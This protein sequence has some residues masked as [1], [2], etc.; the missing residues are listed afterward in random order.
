MRRLVVTVPSGRAPDVLEAARANGAEGVVTLQGEADGSSVDVVLVETANRELEGLVDQLGAIDRMRLSMFPH[1]VLGLKPP[2]EEAPDQVVDVTLRSPLEIL[3]D[4]L[5]SIGSWRGFLAYA[6]VAGIV[7]WIGLIT[8][9]VYLLTA[10]MLIAPFAGPAMNTA[11]GTARG[12][13]ALL[14]RSVVRYA[15]ALAVGVATAWLLTILF[16]FEQPTEQMLAATSISRTAVLLPLVAGAAGAINLGQSERSSLVSGAATGLLVAAALAP[17][18]GV[19]GMAAAMGRWEL[20]TSGA[21]LLGI[22]L[23]GINLSGALVFRLLGLGPR[24]VRFA[25]GRTGV[26][27][28][29]GVA[30][31]LLL[32]GFL[33]WQFVGPV[34][35]ER[36]SLAQRAEQDVHRVLSEVD[37]AV[38]LEVEARFTRS[39]P[40]G[41]ATMLV[42]AYVRHGGDGAVD[43]LEQE[44][45]RMVARTLA[46]R[47]DDT[48]QVVDI[49]VLRP[50]A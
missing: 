39:G 32:A 33:F 31:V 2:A 21:F 26:G 12:D 40:P 47:V 14:R 23:V 5:Q 29:S 18:A 11:I 38:L 17:P 10:A 16:S 24:G 3:L 6:A 20:V 7:V 46:E 9:T 37:E 8:N 13:V 42:T 49:T 34:S 44:L 45:E 1:G 27:V 15:S 41:E 22:Q 4:G 48:T 43:Q 19:V 25:R 30:S 36:S 35:L 50:A 28:A